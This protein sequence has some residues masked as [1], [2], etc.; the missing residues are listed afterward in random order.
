MNLE[1]IRQQTIAFKKAEDDWKANP[2]EG[3][4]YKGFRFEPFKEQSVDGFWSMG[5]KAVPVYEE[6]SDEQG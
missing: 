3:K 2:P 5:Y 4:V 6:D 1:Y